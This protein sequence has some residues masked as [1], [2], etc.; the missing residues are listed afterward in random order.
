MDQPSDMDSE[1][2]AVNMA[3]AEKKQSGSIKEARK[4]KKECQ[5]Q[6]ELC[7]KYSKCCIV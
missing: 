7:R 3:A 2:N 6:E 4:K 1:A 5:L